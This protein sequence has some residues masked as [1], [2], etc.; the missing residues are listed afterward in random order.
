LHP[1]HVAASIVVLVLMA[2]IL[3]PTQGPVFAGVGA[4]IFLVLSAWGV[5]DRD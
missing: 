5:L 4:A 2:S 1:L 3:E